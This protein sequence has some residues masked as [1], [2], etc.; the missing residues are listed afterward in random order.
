MEKYYLMLMDTGNNYRNII[1]KLES[2]H[3]TIHNPKYFFPIDRFYYFFIDITK[4]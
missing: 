1:D 3:R 4:I 2:Y